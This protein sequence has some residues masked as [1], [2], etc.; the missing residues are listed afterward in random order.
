MNCRDCNKY[1]FC[2][3]ADKIKPEQCNFFK[4]IIKVKPVLKKI[5]IVKNNGLKMWDCGY[6]SNTI[7]KNDKICPQ[8]FC[9]IDWS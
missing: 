1:K 8:C 5:R 4:K 2:D 9:E 7:K 3:A 6:C